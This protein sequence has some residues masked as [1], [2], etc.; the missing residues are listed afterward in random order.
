MNLSRVTPFLRSP[1]RCIKLAFVVLLSAAL[2]PF[3]GSPSVSAAEVPRADN[4]SDSRCVVHILDSDSVLANCYFDPVLYASYG[5]TTSRPEIM[6]PTGAGDPGLDINTWYASNS[7]ASGRRFATFTGISNPND[8]TGYA[9]G[10]A[11]PGIGAVSMRL[12]WDNGHGL[13]A[14]STAITELRSRVIYNGASCSSGS[15]CMY[16]TAAG[17]DVEVID[18]D[19]TGYWPA[20]WYPSGESAGSP[21]GVGHR[22]DAV[23]IGLQVNGEAATVADYDSTY[24]PP[25]SSSDA[26]GYIFVATFND[27]NIDTDPSGMKL[28]YRWPDTGGEWSPVFDIIDTAVV[29][30][31]DDTLMTFRVGTSIGRYV[32]QLQFLCDD[33]TQQFP[34]RYLSLWDPGAAITSPNWTQTPE[35]LAACQALSIVFSGDNLTAG[36]E[37]RIRYNLTGSEGVDLAI[38]QSIA[39]GWSTVTDARSESLF[40]AATGGPPFAHYVMPGS[41]YITF[42]VPAITDPVAIGDLLITCADSTGTGF[43]I[44]GSSNLNIRTT[45]GDVDVSCWANSGMSLTSPSSWITGIAKMLGCVAD[46]L[47]VPESSGLADAVTNFNDTMADRP[48]FIAV[49]FLLGFISD[50]NNSLQ[51]SSGDGCFTVGQIPGVVADDDVCSGDAIDVSGSQRSTMALFF[52]A[53]M[54]LG[55]A[56]HMLSLLRANQTEVY[57]IANEHNPGGIH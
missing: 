48:P 25:A 40:G 26:Q 10:P 17:A 28:S 38:N 4:N 34:F 42:T 14:G 33:E 6:S 52:T 55:L 41:G 27:W 1:S 19:G 29:N 13:V 32:S 30:G 49:Y 20:D 9:M 45:L 8:V 21:S 24:H 39:N 18:Y 22:C 5:E 51:N 43:V 16:I 3:G 36:A 53:P 56:S 35:E 11:G 2:L 23:Q 7:A 12:K 44:P 37:A 15:V 50:A 57:Y 46:R 47:F 31:G 54:I